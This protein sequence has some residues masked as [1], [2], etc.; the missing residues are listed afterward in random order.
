MSKLTKFKLSELYEL[1]SGISSKPE[2]AGHGYPFCSFSTVFNNAYLPDA[3][4]DLMDTSENE[5]ITYS[6]KE[7]DVFL[8]RTSETVD[9]LCMSSVA[10]K[11]YPEAT[12]SGFLK[13]LRP[14]SNKAYPKFM[15]LFFRSS[16]FRKTVTNK[17]VMTLRASFN[18][19]VFND[20]Y[21]YLPSMEEQIAI[22]DLFFDVE[23]KIRN[24]NS[25]IAKL[26]SMAKDIYDY[27]F[28]QFDFPD[29]NG[30]PYKS[31]GGKMVWNE[32][33]KME[34]PEGWYLKSLGELCSFANGI[35][36]DKNEAG[37]KIYSIVNVRN[38]TSSSLLLDKNGFDSISLKSSQASRYL[39]NDSDIL[40][41]RSGT[42][43]AT[44]LL[45]ENDGNTVFC[46]F[47]IKCTP[48]C[49]NLKN[50][51]TF[52][53]KNLEGTNLTTTGG[54]ILQNVSQ[55]TLKRIRVAI[56]S[57]VLLDAF[58]SEM[59]PL[60]GKMQNA[61]KENGEVTSLRDWLLPM[62]MNGQVKVGG[63]V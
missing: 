15:A 51:I 55:D 35:N 39:F 21:V 14:I 37:D 47:I 9:E 36:Y 45:L 49:P 12:Y 18:E 10:T 27:W 2:Q 3:L 8:T 22:G 34:V 42:P 31:S 48:N 19:A 4:P 17:A 63:T 5:R 54:S 50:Y 20:I 25:I 26:E 53:L 23:C 29:E 60:L 61:I 6:I 11:D 62:L 30:K 1:A 32:E 46:G 33:L 44:R 59:N 41:A 28:V 38:I 43:G 52:M 7:G 24:N 56:P 16:Y 40:I 13:R 57:P 58:S